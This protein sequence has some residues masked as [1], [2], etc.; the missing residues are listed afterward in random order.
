MIIMEDLKIKRPK[1][2]PTLTLNPKP[3]VWTAEAKA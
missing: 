3:T 1:Q 2:E